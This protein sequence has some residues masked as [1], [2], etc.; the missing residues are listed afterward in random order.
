MKP[1]IMP[2]NNGEMVKIQ[3]RS[4]MKKHKKNEK[5]IWLVND[6][7]KERREGEGPTKVLRMDGEVTQGDQNRNTCIS[8]VNWRQMAGEVMRNGNRNEV[9]IFFFLYFLPYT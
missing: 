1:A 2:S 6:R 8:S 9:I 3:K 7:K 4:D 5:I